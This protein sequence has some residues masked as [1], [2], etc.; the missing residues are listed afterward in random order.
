M[1]YKNQYCII[2]YVSSLHSLG[3]VY[4]LY[5]K[6]K[7]LIVASCLATFFTGCMG[8]DGVVD[9]DKLNIDT[10]KGSYRQLSV[11][12]DENTSPSIY[13]F[14]YLSTDGF[15]LSG[16]TIKGA[17]VSL[18][19]QQHNTIKLDGNEDAS[20]LFNAIFWFLPFAHNE[21]FMYSTSDKQMNA[22][23]VSQIDYQYSVKLPHDISFNKPFNDSLQKIGV[24][25]VNCSAND[26]SCTISTSAKAIDNS[27][28][29]KLYFELIDTSGATSQC[30]TLV[31]KDVNLSNSSVVTVSFDNLKSDCSYNVSLEANKTS[32]DSHDQLNFSYVTKRVQVSV[33]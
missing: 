32:T 23:Q 28:K 29:Y 31:S 21:V 26:K 17:E 22:D 20:R 19:N 2:C 18:Q 25:S 7:L 24:S 14:M 5:K 27:V 8:Y 12:V 6:I 30:P 1:C 33:Q 4:V 10:L 13:Y 15:G 9:A 3:I 16:N 11:R